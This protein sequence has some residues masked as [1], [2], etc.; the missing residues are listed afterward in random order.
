LRV[1]AGRRV[2]GT[3]AHG[4][5]G[6]E[7]EWGGVEWELGGVWEIERLPETGRDLRDLSV[8][9]VAGVEIWC[10]KE[11]SKGGVGSGS[12]TQVRLRA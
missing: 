11:K 2:T 4:P 9:R 8:G 6:D 12:D 5:A 3:R 7:C 1:G 10:E